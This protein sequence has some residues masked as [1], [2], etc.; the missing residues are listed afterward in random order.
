MHDLFIMSIASETLQFYIL[1]AFEFSKVFHGA[2]ELDC[3]A[4]ISF[5]QILGMET[6]LKH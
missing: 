3:I 1:D 5:P 4:C 6:L 2:K